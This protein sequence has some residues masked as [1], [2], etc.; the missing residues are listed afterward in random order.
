M[1][2]NLI[3][4]MAVRKIVKTDICAAMGINRTTFENKL[5]GKSK[6]STSEMYFIQKV[7]FPDVSSEKLFEMTSDGVSA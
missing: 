4:I 5:R 2:A 6:F 1:Y 7:F 3:G